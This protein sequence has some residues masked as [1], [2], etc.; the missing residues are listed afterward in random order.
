[1]LEAILYLVCIGGSC[2][3]GEHRIIPV[4]VA[5]CPIQAQAAAGAGWPD[6]R[7]EKY[8][9]ATVWSYRHGGYEWKP[10]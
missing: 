4:Q 1:M 6:W 10:E 5:A 8:E 7:L 3:P 2:Q 9:C